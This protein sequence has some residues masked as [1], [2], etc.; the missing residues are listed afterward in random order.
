MTNR[1]RSMIDSYGRLVPAIDTSEMS[2]PMRCK[3]CAG[4][5]DAGSVQVVQRYSDCSVWKCPNC[6]ILG[7]DRP[8]SW[9]GSFERYETASE[10]EGW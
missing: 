6:G 10:V 5:H 8:L 9:G 4:V 7:D 2:Y 3:W 1:Q